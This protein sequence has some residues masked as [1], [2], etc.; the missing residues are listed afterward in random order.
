VV[1]IPVNAIRMER[2]PYPRPSVWFSRI[3]AC[4]FTACPRWQ[5]L[6][7]CSVE[8]SSQGS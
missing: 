6:P 7:D 1:V 3:N 5:L 4:S 8:K 2:E